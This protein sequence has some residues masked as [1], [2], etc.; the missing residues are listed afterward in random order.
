[1]LRGVLGFNGTIFSD[2]LSMAG[3]AIGGDFI[4][5]ATLAQEAG[6]DMILVCNNPIAAE[7]VIEKLPIT[8]DPLREQRLQAMRG[9]FS[10][11]RQQLMQHAQWQET[12]VA[13]ESAI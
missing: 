2:D 4:D 6:C 9:K 3:A 1:I 10:L 11:N 5:R 8:Q 7:T 13:L 12:V